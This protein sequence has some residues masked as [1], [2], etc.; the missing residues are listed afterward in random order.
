MEKAS[1]IF[2]QNALSDV[3]EMLIISQKSQAKIFV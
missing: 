2:G 1:K 3:Y